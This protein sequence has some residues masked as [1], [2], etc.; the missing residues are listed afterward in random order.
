MS[1]LLIAIVFGFLSIST[2]YA[3]SVT[4]CGFTSVGI[5]GKQKQT[6][7]MSFTFE[8]PDGDDTLWVYERP[9]QVS[10]NVPCGKEYNYRVKVLITDKRGRTTPK[11]MWIFYKNEI[12]R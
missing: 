8:Q 10:F 12:S 5:G 1:K 3:K 11:V 2:S 9:W 4:E 6:K 7:E